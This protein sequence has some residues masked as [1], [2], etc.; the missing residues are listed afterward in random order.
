M[1]NTHTVLQKKAKNYLMFHYIVRFLQFAVHLVFPC[2]LSWLHVSTTNFCTSHLMLLGNREGKY[3]NPQVFHSVRKVYQGLKLPAYIF[4]VVLSL[5]S[6]PS[7]LW[8]SKLLTVFEEL[9]NRGAPGTASGPCSS[10]AFLGK[11]L[12]LAFCWHQ[13]AAGWMYCDKTV[14]FTC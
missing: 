14:L 8:Y 12:G 13:P 5:L 7:D 10:C 6:F 2:C 9:L 1:G 11:C 4:S 3:K